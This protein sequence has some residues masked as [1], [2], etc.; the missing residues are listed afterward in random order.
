VTVNS[1]EWRDWKPGDG[2]R[3]RYARQ[4]PREVPCGPPV[5]THIRQERVHGKE[6]T[7]VSPVCE[8]HADFGKPPPTK[9]LTNARRLATE[10]LIAE[11]WDVYTKYLHEAVA[12]AQETK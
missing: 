10:R 12:E 2:L 6:R 1:G 4:A 5:R 9:V 8:N 7:V 11:H 3:C